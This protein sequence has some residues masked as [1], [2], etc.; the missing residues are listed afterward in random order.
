MYKKNVDQNK[1]AKDIGVSQSS[2]SQWLNMSKYPRID[3]IEMLADYFNVMK[4]DLTEDKTSKS[5]SKSKIETIAAHIDDDVTEEEM[6]DIVNYIEFIK[7]K[8][9]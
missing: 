1:L 2:I 6:E 4:S 3:R 5:Y 9:Q 7:S 8:K